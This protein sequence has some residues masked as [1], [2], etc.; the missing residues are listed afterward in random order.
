MGAYER[1][2]NFT[3]LGST[4]T[5]EH[6]GV[7]ADVVVYMQ[8]GL[9]AHSSVKRPSRVSPAPGI[10][11]RRPRPRGWRRHAADSSPR[12]EAIT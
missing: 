5:V 7:L 12:T 4:K 2:E 3:L 6:L 1:L 11:D 9:L 8:K 10:P